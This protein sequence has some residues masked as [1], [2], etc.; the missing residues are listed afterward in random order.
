MENREIAGKLRVRAVDEA[1]KPIAGMRVELVAAGARE[2]RSDRKAV[3]AGTV[4]LRALTTSRDGFAIFSLGALPAAA[5]GGGDLA[6]RFAERAELTYPLDRAAA[7]AGS[8]Y[9]SY[10]LPEGPWRELAVVPGRWHDD[11]LEPDDVWAIPGLFPDLDDLEFGDD[12]CGRL[13][14]SDL[15]VRIADHSRLVRTAKDVVTCLTATDSGCRNCGGLVEQGGVNGNIH[16]HE[17]ELIDLQVK[18]VRLGYSFGDLLYSLPLAPCESVTLAISH[19]EQRQQARAEQESVSEEKRSA[20]Y[21]RQNALSETLNAASASNHHQWGVKAGVVLKKI[22]LGVSGGGSYDRTKFASNATR[23]FTDKIQQSSEA[24]RRDHQVVV[25]EQSE[26]E[27]QQ[28]S[29]RTVCNNNHCHVLNIFYHEVLNNYRVTT[30]M[31]GHREVYFVPYE[32]KDFDLHMVL[33]AKTTLLPYLLDAGLAECYAK[34]GATPGPASAPAPPAGPATEPASEF[35]IDIQTGQSTTWNFPAQ[36]LKL[37]VNPSTMPISFPVGNQ[38]TWTPHQSYSYVLKTVEFDPA[39]ISQVGISQWAGMYYVEITLYRISIKDKVTG[40]W[41]TL[42]TGTVGAKNAPFESLIPASYDPP[43]SSGQT[44][45]GQSAPGSVAWTATDKDCADRL[46]AHLNC[47]KLYY[48]SLLWL[49]ED[50]NE[51]FCRFDKIVCGPD[52]ISL[53]D[54]V[55]PEPVG[56]MGCHVAFPKAGGDYVPYAG[57]PIVAEQLLTLPTPGIFADA[58]LGRCSACEK[59]DREVY[60]NWKDSPCPACGTA[61]QLRAPVESPLF[62]AGTLPFAT[63]PTAVWA[64]GVAPP[65]DAVTNSL[66][67]TYGA[68]LATALL[69]GKD[70][71]KDVDKELAELQTLLVKMLEATKEA[72]KAGQ[73][74][75]GDGKATASPPEEPA[76]G[77]EG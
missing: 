60:W 33:C 41:V 49:L 20:A 57:E 75:P 43:A 51:R 1:G 14:P 36:N 13:V 46:L 69:P 68:A 64:T 23:D 16:L 50:P 7:A 2:S 19:W 35:K 67:T 8:Q 62:P 47:H 59:I 42:G 26:T 24:W 54:L 55:L 63:L 71:G 4:A 37:I 77:G 15:T 25:M 39:K 72:A 32:V 61:A 18:C 44:G 74:K 56:V 3:A 45:Q 12:Y 73:T 10:A 66:V 29:Q 5:R 30:K 48:N 11:G 40:Q 53:A 70:S 31:L 34:L 52:K 9:A 22:S 65:T 27:D 58:A 21:F 38:D 76:P 28:V 6:V 17:G